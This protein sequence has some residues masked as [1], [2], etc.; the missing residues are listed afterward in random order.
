MDQRVGYGIL[1]TLGRETDPMSYGRGREPFPLDLLRRGRMHIFDTIDDAKDALSETL[2]RA[3]EEKAPWA[4]PG[5]A[6]FTFVEV[7]T[8]RAAIVSGEI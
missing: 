3:M 2:R 5:K 8:N 6:K 7:V 4:K 1:I